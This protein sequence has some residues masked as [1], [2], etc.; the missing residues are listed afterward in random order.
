MTLEVA[1]AIRSHPDAASTG[2]SSSLIANPGASTPALSSINCETKPFIK[3]AGSK[4]RLLSQIEPYVPRRFRTYVEPFVGGGSLFLHLQPVQAVLNDACIPLVEVWR[5][6]RDDP[7]GVYAE[8]TRRPLA[9][10]AYYAA[11]AERGGSASERGGRFIYLNKGAFNGLYR[12]NLKGE[13]NVPWGAPKSSFI[14]D[15]DNLRAISEIASTERVELMHGDFQAAM[16]VAGDGDFVFVDPP[17]VT[18]HNNNGFIEYNEKIFSWH[19][20]IRLAASVRAAARRGATLLV[21]NARHSSISDLYAGFETVVL[22]RPSTI[23]AAPGKR[24]R[25]EELLV[26]A[27]EH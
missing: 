15:L 8:A 14:A 27:K 22:E 25:V 21:T 9:K 6:V 1:A 7:D 17:Y 5:A 3:W 26:I 20:Q 11:R 12:V 10:E 16:D 13:F 2:A 23:A 24:G 4:R 18:S 19:D